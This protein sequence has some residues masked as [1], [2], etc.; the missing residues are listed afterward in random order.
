MPARD[1][2]FVNVPF[3]RR[4]KKLFD[5]LVFT[6]HDS[7]LL[8]RCALEFEDGT[9]VRFDKL[10][11]IIAEC[12]YGIHDL[13][14]VTL[15]SVNRLPRFNMPLE[16]GL[17]LGAKRYGVGEQRRK[18]S[19][20]LEA[21]SFRYQIY[22]SDIAGQDIRAHGKD[23]ERAIKATRNWLNSARSAGDPLVGHA[24]MAE[25]YYQFRRELPKLC[26][27]G[28]LDHRDLEFVDY[29]R[30]VAGWIDENTP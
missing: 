26:R 19:L 25:R 6:V 7:G 22:C 16:L 2:V 12:R 28:N 5:A 1:S 9:E 20:I 17:F 10:C 11:K 3:D 8:A 13:S 24:K 4:Y 18:S 14:R 30:V 23:A 27:Q 21:Q 15:D 29:R